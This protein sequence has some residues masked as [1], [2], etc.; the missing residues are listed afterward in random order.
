LIAATLDLDLL[1]SLLI[2][3]TLDNGPYT[4]EKHGC[5][6]D[7]GLAHDLGVVVTAHLGCKLNQGVHLF[8]E[9]LHGATS[10]VK[11][12][13]P[14]L[15]ALPGDGRACGESQSHQDLVR[16]DVVLYEALLGS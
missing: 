13:Q 3:E 15:D 9:D 1:T 14:L 2:K 7:E 8:G 5:I 16:L 11:N 6:N 12:V 10:E 4:T